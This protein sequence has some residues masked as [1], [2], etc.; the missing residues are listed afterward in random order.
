MS[1]NKLGNPLY[2]YLKCQLKFF[3]ARNTYTKTNA[4]K[5]FEYELV[6]QLKN[7][8]IRKSYSINTAF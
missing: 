4:H 5:T 1:I 2:I 3:N 6:L 8:P 7:H